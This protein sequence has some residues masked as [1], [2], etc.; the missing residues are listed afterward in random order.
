MKTLYAE[1]Q[2]WLLE[3]KNVDSEEETM[4]GDDKITADKQ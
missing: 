1:V 4:E 3:D 2:W